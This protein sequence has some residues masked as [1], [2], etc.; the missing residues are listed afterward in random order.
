MA[1]SVTTHI[2]YY[3]RGSRRWYGLGVKWESWPA[4]PTRWQWPLGGN[5][6]SGSNAMSVTDPL[7]A[8]NKWHHKC[9]PWDEQLTSL[10]VSSSPQKRDIERFFFHTDHYA[11]R[12]GKGIFYM[13]EFAITNKPIPLDFY[14]LPVAV[15]FPM[16][17]F[18]VDIGLKDPTMD[19]L[20]KEISTNSLSWTKEGTI[21]AASGIMLRWTTTHQAW[22]RHQFYPPNEL[23]CVQKVVD[24]KTS[25]NYYNWVYFPIAVHNGV[26]GT[27]LSY[28][29][30]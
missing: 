30:L 24:S 8:D 6:N 21:C 18:D 13:D 2:R 26:G 3:N 12:A 29:Q 28:Y 7:I 27:L 16:I 5:L 4:M 25:S 11:V 10:R 14:Q 20:E 9:I 15:P 1:P 19:I 22:D 23:D 17:K